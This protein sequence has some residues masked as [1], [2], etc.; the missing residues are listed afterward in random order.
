MADSDD[1]DTHVDLPVVY[2]K[3]LDII[4]YCILRTLYCENI[5]LILQKNHIFTQWI[6]NSSME[7][8]HHF[9]EDKARK[10][11]GILRYSDHSSSVYIN[12]SSRFIS[13]GTIVV[14]CGCR[15]P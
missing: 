9:H 12:R 11:V 6:S 13:I 5:T 14:A 2:R 4:F 7:M 1:Q 3:C 10:R 8:H 15:R